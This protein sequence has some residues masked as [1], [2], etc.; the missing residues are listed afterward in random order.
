MPTGANVGITRIYAW[1][2]GGGA[3]GESPTRGN[4]GELAQSGP[5]LN[6]NI[7][8]TNHLTVTDVPVHEPGRIASRCHAADDRGAGHH[9]S[10]RSPAGAAD[11][12][13]AVGWRYDPGAGRAHGAQRGDRAPPRAGAWE[14]GSGRAAGDPGAWTRT[15]GDRVRALG[16]SGGAVSAAGG[17]GPERARRASEGDRERSRA[18]VILRRIHRRPPAGGARARQG[19]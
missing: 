18:A 13:Q 5:A 14:A 16:C 7:I 1:G 11:P 2:A 4:R 8:L 12:A 15:T 3:V 17:R 9:A 10:G 19:P 6:Q